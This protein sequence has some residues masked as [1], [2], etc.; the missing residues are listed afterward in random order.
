MIQTQLYHT[1]GAT[2][3]AV[4]R[5]QAINQSKSK[6]YGDE[7]V[8]IH[9]H[10]ADIDCSNLRHESYRNGLIYFDTKQTEI[11]DE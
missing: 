8:I 11:L 2:D 4:F 5:R 6:H 1:E 10:S 3:I 9:H 7:E